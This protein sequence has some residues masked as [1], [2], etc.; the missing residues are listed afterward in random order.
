M[1]LGV[2]QKHHRVEDK[3]KREIFFRP[4]KEFKKMQI[5]PTFSMKIMIVLL[6]LTLSACAG[7]ERGP[8]ETAI[9]KIRGGREILVAR[10]INNTLP[11]WCGEGNAMIYEYYEEGLFFHDLDTG[12]KL[13]LGG[14]E[15]SPVAC[16]PDGEWI[17]Y[18]DSSNFHWTDDNDHNQGVVKELWRYNI[19]TGKKETFLIVDGSRNNFGVEK[20]E[21][22]GYRLYPG[23]K[24]L[25]QI[26]MP[27]P[28]WEVVWSLEKKVGGEL[29][30][31]DF[32]AIIG[33]H[34][35][36]IGQGSEQWREVLEIE[37][38][39]P[40]RKIITLYPRSMRFYPKVMDR[41]NRLY[42]Q[43]RD[44]KG[45]GTIIE[46]CTV[47]LESETLSCVPVLRVSRLVDGIESMCPRCLEIPLKENRSIDGFDLLSDNETML[48]TRSWDT[49]VHIKRAGGDEREC[50][51]TMDHETA[52]LL[53]ISPDERWAVFTVHGNV[54]W[55]GSSLYG[56]IDL[57]AV[58]LIK[59]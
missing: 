8:E 40:E 5:K 47:D 55:E 50:F 38:L 23:E 18:A 11:V 46:R 57:Y 13:K 16:T 7:V 39:K 22:G 49:C 9:G 1:I 28:K 6:M 3:L 37:V 12:K 21:S 29:W 42:I 41:M 58:E 56:Q 35:I 2:E 34:T 14:A 4:E 20:L 43:R 48:Y 10:N 15:A 33:N 17:I 31:S 54:H 26:E 25:K 51:T 53:S 32:S 52:S 36:S 45:Y 44:S 19:A 24:P 59:E 30:F 27:K